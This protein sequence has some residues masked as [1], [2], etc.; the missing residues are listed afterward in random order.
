MGTPVLVI[1]SL[2]LF[3]TVPMACGNYE[4]RDQT[5]AIAMTQA[6]AVMM[7]DP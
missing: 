7:L 4:V 5:L 1:I 2:F 3:L 6:A